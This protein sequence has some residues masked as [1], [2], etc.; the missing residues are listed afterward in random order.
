MVGFHASKNGFRAPSRFSSY[1]SSA[2]R[3]LQSFVVH[4]SVDSYLTFV[5][6]FLYLVF[7]SVC[8]SERLCFVIVAFSGLRIF[9]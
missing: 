3:L 8:D 9:V 6:S 4:A 7:S 1:R 5:M 2:V